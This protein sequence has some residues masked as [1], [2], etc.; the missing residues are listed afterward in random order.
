MLTVFRLFPTYGMMVAFKRWHG[1]VGLLQ[2]LL[3]ATG[4]AAYPLDDDASVPSAGVG[5]N[6]LVALP[7]PDE[8]YPSD[9]TGNAMRLSPSAVNVPSSAWSA[10]S[11]LAADGEMPAPLFVTPS[12]ASGQ[13][14]ELADFGTPKTLARTLRAVVNVEARRQVGASPRRAALPDEQ[15]VPLLDEN[16]AA[17]L[18]EIE[19]GL[20]EVISDALDARIDEEGRVTFS[21][22]GIGG[23][24]LT[25][26]S[27]QISIGHGDTKLTFEQNADYRDPGVAA[28]DAA[29]STQQRA[30]PGGFNPLRELIDLIVRVVQYPL[31][32]VLL[33]LLVIGKITLMIATARSKRR[34]RRRSSASEPPKVKRSRTRVKLKRIRTRIKL[35]QP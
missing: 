21:L 25:A 19:E 4:V 29:R 2:M 34:S 16:V 9:V 20:A 18:R 23:F 32:W 8:A 15:M 28:I 3:F 30:L 13:D 27:G 5:H 31:V 11:L 12:P 1:F 10:D 24:H 14:A 17:A 33:L 35:Q 22:F 7:T 26:G 6:A